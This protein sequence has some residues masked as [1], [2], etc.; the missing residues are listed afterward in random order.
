[1]LTGIDDT[2][3]GVQTLGLLNSND[4]LYGPLHVTGI[5]LDFCGK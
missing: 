4:L 3:S 2:A 5:A 1:M